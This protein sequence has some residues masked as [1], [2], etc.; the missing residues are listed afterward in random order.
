MRKNAGDQSMRREGA[1]GKGAED[2]RAESN[3]AESERAEGKSLEPGDPEDERAEGNRSQRFGKAARRPPRTPERA[4]ARVMYLLSA[5][6]YTK[7]QLAEKLRKSD[8][9]EEVIEAVLTE[10]AELGYLDDAGYARDYISAH[11]GQYGRLRLMQELQK[12][13]ISGELFETAYAGAL[14][15][16]AEEEGFAHAPEEGEYEQIRIRELLR[17]KGFSEKPA[18]LKERRRLYAFLARRGFSHASI[19]AVLAA[20]WISEG[21][22]GSELLNLP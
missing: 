4:R 9:A 17:R 3:G 12:R 20:S 16:K 18:D 8:Y 19:C 21:S 7:A 14:E 5:R 15:G 22:D 2:G 10:Y 11:L 13:G 6:D 1:E